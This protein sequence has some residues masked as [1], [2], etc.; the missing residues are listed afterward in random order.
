MIQLLPNRRTVLRAGGAVV[1]LPILQSFCRARD[2]SKAIASP[3]RLAFVYAPNGKHMA[4]WTPATEGSNYIL[5][6]TLRELEKIRDSVRVLSGLSQRNANALDE[7][8]GDH[9]RAMANFLTGVR[10]K[11]TSGTDIRN[12][13]SVDQVAASA[14]G[15]STRFPSLEVGCEAGKTA[16]ICDNGYSCIY[17]TNL[18][19]RNESTP[20]PKEINPRSVFERL[21]GSGGKKDGDAAEER[22]ERDR[23]SILDFVAADARDLSGKLAGNDRR[24][25]DEFLTSVREVERRIQRTEPSIPVGSSNLQPPTGIPE[26]YQDH[27]R[28]L[29]DL[30]ALAFQTDQTRVAT[31]VLGNDGS[32]RSYREVGVSEGHHDL[33]HHAGDAVKHDKL[34]AIN[35]LHLAQFT[36]LVTRLRSI[37][38]GEGTLL[39]RCSVVYGSGI[40]DGDRHDHDDLPI[41]LAGGRKEGRHIRYTQGTPLCNLYLSLLAEIGMGVQR[42][43]DS[44]GPL[45][46]LDG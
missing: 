13:I 25:L 38:E 2:Q 37:P 12:G 33:S 43:G 9:A 20:M 28:L 17:Q 16:G 32:N 7:G 18:S 41:L 8:A 24:K 15:R 26:N 19:W 36:H 29:A 5:P 31:F 44:T 23:R 39:D 45:S 21:F 27:A 11:K 6:P 35:R 30:I 46:G 14:L 22:R 42:F 10:P 40:R 4:D 3:R 1:A 34:K